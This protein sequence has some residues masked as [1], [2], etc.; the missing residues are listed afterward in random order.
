[1]LKTSGFVKTSSVERLLC[2]LVKRYTHD[3]SQIIVE[4]GSL[5]Q[6]G[7]VEGRTVTVTKLKDNILNLHCQMAWIQ[8]KTLYTYIP[9]LL[10]LKEAKRI[11][12]FAFR[13]YRKLLDIYKQSST[14]EWTSETIEELGY[15]LEPILM[16]FQEQ[17]LISKDWRCLGFMTTQLNFTN[18]LILKKLTLGEQILL[19]PYLN[20]V[21]EQVAVPWQ[22]VCAAAANYEL[23]SLNFKLIEKILPLA[24]E[25][26]Q[27]VYQRLIEL[28]PDYRTRR[29]KLTDS[30]ITHSCLRD[31]HMFQAYLW[32]CFLEESIEP[33]ESELLPLCQM[34]AQGVGI[35][36]NMV[37]IW[38][39][40]LA[41]EMESRVSKEEKFLL[42]PYTK[43]IQE[44]FFQQRNRFIF[45]ESSVI[46][47]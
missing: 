39:Q 21:E 3:L 18:K 17:H 20:F 24:D 9:N 32:L 7:S 26:A 41:R 11:T 16:V 25:I 28:L 10:D 2:L 22:R 37:E 1:M 42:S 19:S 38:C 43:G 15:A 14:S 30:G 35:K 4:D 13:V 34:V 6:A 12:Q 45:S 23:D 31:L 33:I 44:I 29:G 36:W 47:Y 8:T 5:L 46:S 27:A 40:E